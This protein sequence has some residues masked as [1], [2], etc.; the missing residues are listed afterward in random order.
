MPFFTTRVSSIWLESGQAG[1]AVD[2]LMS[3]LQAQ[4][5]LRCRDRALSRDRGS[6]RDDRHHDGHACA[7]VREPDAQPL[8]RILSPSDARHSGVPL[9]LAEPCCPESKP[10]P[11][12]EQARWPATTDCRAN[13]ARRACPSTRRLAF[14][15]RARQGYPGGKTKL[16]SFGWMPPQLCDG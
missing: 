3:Q 4:G 5:R 1:G 16:A 15:H 10:V 6:N 7:A 2:E 8:R 9:G 12:A 13:R 11:S 14:L